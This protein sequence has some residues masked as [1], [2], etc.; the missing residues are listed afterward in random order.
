MSTSTPTSPGELS[1]TGLP[2]VDLSDDAAGG[3]A[4]R[5]SVCCGGLGRGFSA[6]MLSA[7]AVSMLLFVVGCGLHAFAVSTGV[8]AD[9]AWF[10]VTGVAFL[11]ITA[12]SHVVLCQQT[13]AAPLGPLMISMA[14][15]L[16]GTFLILGI[17]LTLS[18]LSRPEAVF[19]VLFWYIT[20]T[21]ADLVGVVKQK[22]C[23]LQS[24]SATGRVQV[25]D[26]A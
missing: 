17:V 16:T 6:Q 22:S 14:I 7:M 8:V 19:N 9:T 15:R 21:S 18:P 20:L 13:G 24:G 26:Q 23:D 25:G 3:A 1:A 4:C 10:A 12:I 2:Q 5:S 11:I